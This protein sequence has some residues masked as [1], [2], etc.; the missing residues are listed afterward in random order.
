MKMNRFFCFFVPVLFLM[1]CGDDDEGI[2]S[3]PPRELTEVAVEDDAEIQAF[4]QTH[5]YNYEEFENPPADFDFKIVIDTI[6]GANADRTPL[7]DQMN[8]RSDVVN[9]SA[10][11]FLLEGEENI[12]HTY[13]CLLYTSPSPRD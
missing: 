1:S 6:A 13:Y 12:P 8:L 11:D 3:T 10:T 2:I 4:L 7:A 9:I 5:F